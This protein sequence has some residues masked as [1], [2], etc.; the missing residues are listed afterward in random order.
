MLGNLI[1]KEM[2]NGSLKLVQNLTYSNGDKVKRI[3][4]PKTRV[5]QEI[6]RVK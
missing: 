6:I 5:P 4:C 2:I 1:V 3:L